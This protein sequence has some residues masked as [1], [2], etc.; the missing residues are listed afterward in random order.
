MPYYAPIKKLTPKNLRK[1][2]LLGLHRLRTQLDAEMPQKTRD[3][4]LILGTWN[5]RNFD[6]NRFNSGPRSKEDMYYLAE[7][8]SRFDILAVQEICDD[9]WPMKQLM[10]FLG[11]DYDYILTDI[12][13]GRSGNNERLGFIYDKAKA[14]FTHI[15]GEVVLPENMQISDVDKKRQFSRTPFMCSFQAGW[16]RFNFSTVHIY[17]GKDSG[18]KY[19]RRVKEIEAIARSIS[20]KAKKNPGNHILVGDFN[21]KKPGSPGY[22][23]LDKNGFTIFQNNEGSN[24][25]QTKFYDQISFMARDNEIRLSAS[26]KCQGV[27]Q[28]FNSIYREEDFTSY[29]KDLH[30]AVDN[31][32]RKQK[33]SIAE[34]R[35]KLAKTQSVKQ[36]DKHEKSLVKMKATLTNWN[37][38]LTSDTKLRNFYLSDWRTFHCS[39]HLPLWVELEVDFSGNYLEYLSSLN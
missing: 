28:F 1:R 14:S 24:K 2:T 39:D 26:E 17:F 30:R 13:E 16:F 18:S 22:N 3:E 23:A 6:D 7:I 29:R 19:E 4:T 38:H 31:K 9:L 36:K 37:K 25:D 35:R 5:I 34:T 21:I 11:R 8:I 32:I 33:E 20:R 27:L 12:T 15:A 10:R